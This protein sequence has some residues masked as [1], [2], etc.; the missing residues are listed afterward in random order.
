MK[1]INLTNKRFLF[2][3]PEE[4]LVEIPPRYSCPLVLEE[5]EKI[6]N[7]SKEFGFQIYTKSHKL[8]GELPP[9]QT[10][11]IYIVERWV[12]DACQDRIDLFYVDECTDI[13]LDE[14]EKP[15]YI[16]LIGR[17]D[18]YLSRT[19]IDKIRENAYIKGA[20]ETGKVIQNW[21][22]K[23]RRMEKLGI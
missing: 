22:V 14:F 13:C 1:I 11:I 15:A 7:L 12:F 8:L 19:E 21:L 4:N 10:D 20:R 17:K 16:R 5:L 18:S 23:E 3:N 6:E 2:L 9:P